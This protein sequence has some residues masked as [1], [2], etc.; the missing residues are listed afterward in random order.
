MEELNGRDI[1][2]YPEMELT[3]E[4]EKQAKNVL[5]CGPTGTGKTTF[6]QGF[7][8]A[9]NKV[10]FDDKYRYRIGKEKENQLKL[11]KVKGCSVTDDVTVY[12]LKKE[13][14]KKKLIFRLIDAPGYGDTR[15][16]KMDEHIMEEYLD[17]FAG[18]FV[19]EIHAICFTSKFSETRLDPRMKKIMEKVLTMFGKNV[20]DILVFLFTF[21][22]I[23]QKPKEAI[24]IL[25]SPDSP[26]HGII[27]EK[28]LKYFCFQNNTLFNQSTK[29]NDDEEEEDEKDSDDEDES[30]ESDDGDET[31]VDKKVFKFTMKNYKKLIK[32]VKKSKGISLKD[33]QNVLINRKRIK[34]EI[35]NS[36]RDTKSLATSLVSIQNNNKYIIDKEKEL[37]QINEKLNDPMKVTVERTRERTIYEEK[38]ERRECSKGY[39]CCHCKN[40]NK[41]CHFDCKFKKESWLPHPIVPANHC[42]IIKSE[43]CTSC[44]CGASSHEINS[45]YYVKVICSKKVPETYYEVVDAPDKQTRMTQNQLSKQRINEDL[46]KLKK[47]SEIAKNNL[48]KSLSSIVVSMKIMITKNNE[49]Q[50]DALY[51]G[52]NVFE[53]CKQRF[54]FFSRD[55]DDNTR[56][57]L[58]KFSQQLDQ[59][60]SICYGENEQTA[61]LS[62][63]RFLSIDY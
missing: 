28:K 48:S 41:E 12:I 60:K 43:K 18:R 19:H 3:E 5:M 35:D 4:E 23:G 49:L 15:G 61:V 58:N 37:Q 14:K 33:S 9:F 56:N 11:N 24:E 20:K 46:N 57:Y 7:V 29:E 62:L 63:S 17:V 55:S 54:T 40:C 51:P 1:Y 2:I 52:E 59:V 10:K 32:F 26:F 39:Y 21:A 45:Y 47:E 44:S 50:K 25:C 30:S 38:T 31:N 13:T 53:Y 8:N 16:E 42:N 6:I 34:A 22:E 27:S 36:I